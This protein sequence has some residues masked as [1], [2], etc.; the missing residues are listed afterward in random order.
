MP[1]RVLVTRR[2]PEA[3]LDR[4]RAAGDMDLNTEDRALTRDEL[5]ARIRG[6]AALVCLLTDTIDG[7]AMDAAGPS[8]KVIA[9]YAVGYNNID[10]PAASARRIPVTNTP[11]VLTDATADLTWALILDTTRRV[12]EGDRI[13][14]RGGF[15]GWSPL[16]HLGGEVSGG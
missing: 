2:L 1:P 12:S 11:D 10:V 5:L 16:Y 7:A 3:A 9:N 4:L 13:M 14:R 15:P 6:A 8:L